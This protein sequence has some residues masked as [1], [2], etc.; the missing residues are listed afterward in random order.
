M[1]NQKELLTQKS[2][3]E[4]ELAQ[5]DARQETAQT[6]LDAARELTVLDA[7]AAS[8]SA[9][10]REVVAALS[11]TIA[12]KRDDLAQVQT[13][14]D[15]LDAESAQKAALDAEAEKWAEFGADCVALYSAETALETQ[16]EAFGAEVEKTLAA[17]QDADK[18]FTELRSSLTLKLRALD[19]YQRCAPNMTG[20]NWESAFEPLFRQ[21]KLH[22]VGYYSLIRTLAGFPSYGDGIPRAVV[23]A[24]AFATKSQ[25]IVSQIAQMLQSYRP[26]RPIT[27]E[28]KPYEGKMRV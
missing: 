22:E 12:A 21:A 16:M 24:K 25:G 1:K 27:R 4:T 15:A 13:Q 18:R 26:S 23:T 3:L 20:H 17:M 14:L 19:A 2:E 7:S 28:V 10:A 5:L 6:D 8:H 9:H 11:D